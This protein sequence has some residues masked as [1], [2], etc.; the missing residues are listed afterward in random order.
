V[1]RSWYPSGGDEEHGEV[2]GE[3][4]DDAE[5]HAGDEADAAVVG[6]VA[7]EEKGDFLGDGDA[8]SAG[9]EDDEDREMRVVLRTISR[10]KR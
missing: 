10:R 1:R 2:A 6:G 7:G 9:V 8:Q 5:D 3:D 4:G